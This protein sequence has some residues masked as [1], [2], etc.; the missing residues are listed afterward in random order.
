MTPE[1]KKVL[2]VLSTTQP[3]GPRCIARKTGLPLKVVS[4][5]CFKN[6]QIKRSLDPSKVGSGKDAKNTKL[7]YAPDKDFEFV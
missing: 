1:S 5:I 7:F 6:P 4:S 2:E 3:K